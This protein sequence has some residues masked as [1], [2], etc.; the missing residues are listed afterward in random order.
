MCILIYCII[1]IEYSSKATIKSFIKFHNSPPR[2]LFCLK[3]SSTLSYES[4]LRVLREYHDVVSQNF[5]LKFCLCYNKLLS[6]FTH[7][8]TLTQVHSPLS[9]ILAKTTRQA[10]CTH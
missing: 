5:I 4:F 6:S 3:P 1:L 10:R 2:Q 8:S 7:A 9:K